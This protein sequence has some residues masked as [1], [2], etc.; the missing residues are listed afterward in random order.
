MS[1]RFTAL[2]GQG[3]MLS[4]FV[5]AELDDKYVFDG[6]EID[7]QLVSGRCPY[8]ITTWPEMDYHTRAQG[9]GVE[10]GCAHRENGSVIH[11]KPLAWSAQFTTGE[12]EY[13]SIWMVEP[14]HVGLDEFT[15]LDHHIDTLGA[16]SNFYIRECRVRTAQSG[17]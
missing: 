8:T 6:T 7:D 5:L 4:A 14:A 1:G 9:R 16:F 11:N 10:W 13:Q 12:I 17:T 2:A 3:G 15:E